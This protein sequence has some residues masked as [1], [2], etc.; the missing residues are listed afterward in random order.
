L[1]LIFSI[2]KKEKEKVKEE[3]RRKGT[4]K[5]DVIIVLSR[6]Y[7]PAPICP[8]LGEMASLFGALGST[9]DKKTELTLVLCTLLALESG[10]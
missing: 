10:L 3:E 2:A 5:G 9:S 8:Q 1:R 7:F 4:E 6:K